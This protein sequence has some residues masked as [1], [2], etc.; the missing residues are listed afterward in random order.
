MACRLQLPDQ[1]ANQAACTGS[2]EPQ[3]LNHQGSALNGDFLM[4]TITH[5]TYILAYITLSQS[6]TMP[7]HGCD[8]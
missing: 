7:S 4:A 6:E 8:W 3:S 2:T 1:E 5:E